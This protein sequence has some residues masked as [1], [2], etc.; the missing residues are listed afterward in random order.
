MSAAFACDYGKTLPSFY[1]HAFPECLGEL[2]S[3]VRGDK[4]CFNLAFSSICDYSSLYTVVIHHDQEGNGFR[5][6]Y[7][8]GLITEERGNTTADI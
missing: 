5:Q 1:E 8:V 6:A 7:C 4:E 2:N 3:Y